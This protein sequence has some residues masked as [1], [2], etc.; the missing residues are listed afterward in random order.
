MTPSALIVYGGYAG[1]EP[2]KTTGLVAGMLGALDFETVQV[3]ELAPL[4]DAA[5]L[6][7][8]DLIVL[9]WSVDTVTDE[10]VAGLA[11][12]VERGTGFAGW[13]GGQG[14]TLEGSGSLMFLA[15]GRFVAP[16]REGA[17]HRPD[18]RPPAPDHRRAG[19]FQPALGAVLH[20]G[21]S[22]QPRAG[23]D[24]FWRRGSLGR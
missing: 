12:A 5:Y 2:E 18:G 22:V 14:V 7:G 6:S 1:H 9:N 13:H 19:R 15:G 20:A 10:Q 21:R 3:P 11:A 4:A 16:G 24:D 23:D 17:L 8:F